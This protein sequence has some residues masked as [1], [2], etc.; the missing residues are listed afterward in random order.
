[1]G[2]GENERQRV[3]EHDA[4]VGDD[5]LPQGTCLLG[6][7]GCSGQHVVERLARVDYHGIDISGIDEP[8]AHLTGVEY[9]LELTHHHVVA[10]HVLARGS[11]VFAVADELLFERHSVGARDEVRCD[12]LTTHTAVDGRVKPGGLLTLLYGCLVSVAVV[13]FGGFA[14]HS[15]EGEKRGRD[16]EAF[17][18]EKG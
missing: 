2:R 11:A 3:F 18:W 1:M 7:R 10:Q 4:F 17:H 15:G 12:G 6:G 5:A 8:L 16:E 9:L 14:R 13:G